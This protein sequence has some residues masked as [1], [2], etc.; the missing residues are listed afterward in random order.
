MGS[1]TG[2]LASNFSAHVAK[3]EARH[4]QTRRVKLGY[5]KTLR[6]TS[7]ALMFKQGKVGGTWIRKPQNGTCVFFIHGI[8]SD[9]EQA[10][11]NGA[12]T[13][14]PKLLPLWNLLPGFWLC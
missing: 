9:G 10:W 13:T 14:W 7:E 3:R 11:M 5:N 4:C 12:G 2:S 1:S 8:L 6:R